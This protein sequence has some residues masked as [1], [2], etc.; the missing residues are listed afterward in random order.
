MPRTKSKS[1]AAARGRARGGLAQ[2][3]QPDEALAKLIG[4]DPQPRSEIT[5]RIWSY[6]RAKGLQDEADRRQIKTD[7]ALRAIAGGKDRLH[8]FELPRLLNE[9]LRPA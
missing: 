7:P 8:M 2:P 3:M 6:I 5:K 9:H 4:D 1:S